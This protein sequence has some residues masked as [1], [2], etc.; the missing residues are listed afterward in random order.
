MSKMLSVLPHPLLR[1]RQGIRKLSEISDF[2][3]L[4]VQVEGLDLRRG[5]GHLGLKRALGFEPKRAKKQA[6]PPMGA[7][8]VWSE[9]R[10][11]N[12]RPDGPKLFEEIFSAR[13]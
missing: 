7:L 8:L 6:T 11:S 12:P 3:E 2:R 10:G 5:A 13:L 9:W 4:L 1:N